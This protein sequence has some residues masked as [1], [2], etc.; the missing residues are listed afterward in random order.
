MP[1]DKELEQEDKGVDSLATSTCKE[2]L[3]VLALILSD[4]NIIAEEGK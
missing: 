3:F 1:E 2:I 4:G